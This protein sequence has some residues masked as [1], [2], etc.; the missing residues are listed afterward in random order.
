LLDGLR[1][2]AADVR[3]LTRCRADARSTPVAVLALVFLVAAAASR[4]RGD[5]GLQSR[6]WL[7]IGTNFGL[8][9]LTL[10]LT[11]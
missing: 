7:L 1:R 3:Q 4:A 9:S 8:V 10:F 5:R 11:G 2:S 6:T